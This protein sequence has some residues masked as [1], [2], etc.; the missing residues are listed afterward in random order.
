MFYTAGTNFTRLP[1]MTVATNLNSGKELLSPLLDNIDGDFV[2]GLPGWC[3]AM[4]DNCVR[5]L[6]PRFGQ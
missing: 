3:K 5:P 2:E 4:A 1:V 6:P